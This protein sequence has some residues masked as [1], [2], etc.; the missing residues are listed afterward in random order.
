MNKGKY[1]ISDSNKNTFLSSSEHT[2]VLGRQTW[3]KEKE[4]IVNNDRAYQ[5]LTEYA[6][7]KISIRLKP[8]TP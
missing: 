6:N 4:E 2:L 5:L 1:K 3:R 8:K 7:D